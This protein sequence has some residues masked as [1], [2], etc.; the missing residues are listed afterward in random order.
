MSGSKGILF[1]LAKS[2]KD[3]ALRKE[4]IK[5][6]GLTGGQDELWQ[7]YQSEQDKENKA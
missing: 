3:P 1:D 5:Q 4:A 2:E 7:L 6:L